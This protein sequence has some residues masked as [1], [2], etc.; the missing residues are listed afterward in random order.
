MFDKIK[1]I[2]IDR[3]NIIYLLS[4]L[5]SL[6]FFGGFCLLQFSPDTYSVFSSTP[7]SIAS[8]FG[9][10]G[11]Y[12]TQFFIFVFMHIFKLPH[13]V[14]Y[15]FSYFLGLLCLSISISRLFN[16]MNKDVKNKYLC[17]ILSTAMVINPFSIE[18]FMY[19]EK[20]VMTLAILLCI[21]AVEKVDIGLKTRKIKH[22]IISLIYMFIANC[23]YQGVVGF[24]VVCS[25]V[26]IIKYG[27]SF[28][29]FLFNNLYVAFIYGI[30]TGLNYIS[31]KLFFVNQ[32]FGGSKVFSESI[33]KIIYGIKGMLVE[34]YNILP[35]YFYFILCSLVMILCIVI[36][37]KTKNS[38]KCKI[39]KI[40]AIV[41]I[42]IVSLLAT[43][44]PQLFQNTNSIWFVARSSYPMLSVICILIWYAFIN[45]KS[46][47]KYEF[48]F[49]L[50]I[51]CL[52]AVQFVYFTRMTIDNYI[53]N[54]EDRVLSEK[55]IRAI[56]DYEVSKG[57]KVENISIYSDKSILY[58]YPWLKTSGDMNIRA[59]SVNW[60]FTKA[61]EFY[62]GR[63][64][65]EVENDIKIKKY[66]S[67]YDWN[68]FDNK[69]IIFDG[70]TVHI[71]IY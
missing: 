23:C 71:S 31:I 61:L 35:S 32:R 70:N 1:K 9:S 21:L 46:D 14:I 40:L 41:Y 59:Y 16:L 54:Y 63:S 2:V 20:G 19:I 49:S 22:F 55:L 60:C 18:L 13:L 51:I 6:V 38:F 15:Y 64:F 69:Q 67:S 27:K 68:S 53:G 48:C 57:L 52:L 11:R 3:K 29:S 8:H 42:I 10:C 5:V 44:A 65:N 4:L 7:L 30:S 36:F 34:T 58:A 39:L 33:R 43:V 62:S 12:V 26:L 28:K 24:F 66:F 45:F 37:F 56:D 47:F 17:F 50:I 25:L